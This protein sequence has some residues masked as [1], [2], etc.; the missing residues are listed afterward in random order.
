MTTP[1]TLIDPKILGL[2]VRG[3][4]E[5]QHVSQDALA[6]AENIDVRTIQRLEAGQAVNEPLQ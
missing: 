3:I 2:S 6:G 5:T 4:R 1:P